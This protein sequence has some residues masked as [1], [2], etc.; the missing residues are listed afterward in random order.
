[1]SN[2]TGLITEHT[3][4]ELDKLDFGVNFGEKF[5]GLRVVKFEEILKKFSCHVIMNV[6][7]KPLS[8]EEPYPVDMMK[9]IVELIR[10]YD[11]EKYV[12]LMLETDLQIK[13]FKEYAPDI[14]VCVGHLKDRPWDIVDRAIEFGCEKVQL[15]KPYFN[16][17]MIDKA[18]KNG[19]VCNVF[20]S[21]DVKETK[22]FLEMGI[23][24]ILTNNYN[25]IS[26]NVK[27]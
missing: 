2:G 4:S 22:E 27:R 11:C 26:Q 8:Y 14:A 13:Q 23:D 7:I 17:D 1:V 25:L 20:W 16:Q 15:F 18:H 9:K 6:H 21:D 19:I 5:K 24:V 12:Y 10:K 3:L